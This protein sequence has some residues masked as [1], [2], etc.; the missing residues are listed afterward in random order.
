MI[1]LLLSNIIQKVIYNDELKKQLFN[2]GAEREKGF[3]WEK[4]AKKTK[5]LYKDIL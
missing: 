4:T 3:T 1:I 5:M 2:K